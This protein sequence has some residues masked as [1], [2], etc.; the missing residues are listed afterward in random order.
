M[1]D[2]N[3]LIENNKHWVSKMKS[4]DPNYFDQFET[5]SPEYLWI[6]CCDSRVPATQ[7]V[8]I[9]PGDM[10]VHRNIANMVSLS[11]INCM[12]AIKYAVD[13]LKVKHII[14]CGHYGCGGVQASMVRDNQFGIIDH[15]LWELKLIHEKYES[16]LDKVDDENEKWK[17]LCEI[18]VKEQVSNL[19]KSIPVSRAWE[20]NEEITLHGWIYGINDG[21]LKDLDVTCDSLETSKVIL[22]NLKQY[23]S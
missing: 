16:Y 11:D 18:N 20:A 1:K 7:I 23:N 13:V 2:L 8:D 15:W 21:L 12:S 3:T 9:A 14:V 5:Q 22:K 6:G 17:L 4:N 10:F 19:A